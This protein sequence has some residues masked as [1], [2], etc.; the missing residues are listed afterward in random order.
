MKQ[1]FEKLRDTFLAGLLFLLPVLIVLVLVTKVWGY[2]TGFSSKIAATFGLKTIVGIPSG[3]VVTAIGIVL[4]CILCGYLVRIALFKSFSTYLDQKLLKNIPVYG[5]YREM[6]YQ[7]VEKKDE[8]LPYNGVI[9]LKGGPTK[10]PGFLI[11]K[12]P[13][14]HC[15]IFLPSGGNVKEGN[16]LVV[17]ESEIEMVENIEMKTVQTAL[18]NRGIGLAKA[19]EPKKENA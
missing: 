6:A 10:Q 15:V 9:F 18:S 16:V 17:N 4:F 11:E 7:K 19:L 14:G 8:P 5:V 13:N 2:L 3:T 12:M 1:L